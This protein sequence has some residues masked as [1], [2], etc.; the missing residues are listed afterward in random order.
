MPALFYI[1]RFLKGEFLNSPSTLN[2]VS[3]AL[4]VPAL[5]KLASPQHHKRHLSVLNSTFP[6]LIDTPNFLFNKSLRI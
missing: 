1:E 2:T 4:M 3:S 6:K 5:Y